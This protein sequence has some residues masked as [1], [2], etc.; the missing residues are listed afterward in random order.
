MD[1]DPIENAQDMR[2]GVDRILSNYPHFDRWHSDHIVPRILKYGSRSK[3]G[4]ESR[5][6]GNIINVYDDEPRKYIE[7]EGGMDRSNKRTPL[8]GMYKDRPEFR[9]PNSI[10]GSGPDGKSERNRTERQK[11]ASETRRNK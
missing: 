3:Q 6:I 5:R 2:K 1:V 11:N 10:A 4:S 8:V 9:R 7:Y